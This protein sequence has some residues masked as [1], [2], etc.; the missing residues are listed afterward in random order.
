[1]SEWK[2]Y[3]IGDLCSTISNTYNGSDDK[4][5]LINT[6]DV[7]DGK[8]LNHNF[9]E[10]KNLKG[11][12]KK[13]FIKNDIL[14]SEIRPAN[15]RFAFIDF[16]KT[17]NY[18]VS[19]KLMVLRPDT[20]KVLPSFLFSILK[21]QTVIDELQHL[22]ETRSGTFPQITFSSELAPMKVLLPNL[23]IQAKIVSILYSIEEKISTN[24]A[25][26]NN[27]E[28]QAQAIFKSWFVDFE[29]FGGTMP[30][31]W[32]ISTLSIVADYLNGLAM[33]KF[34]PNKNEKGIPVLKIKELKQGFC[35]VQSDLCSI[36]IKPEYLIN[37]GD[38]IFSWSGTLLLDFWCSGLC[39]LNQHLFKVS[40][41]KYDKWFYYFWTKHHLDTFI[42][43]A[44]DKATTMGHIKREDLDKSE[45]LIPDNK[46][47]K[48]LNSILSPLINLIIKNRVE[49]RQL[50]QLR[51]T[52]LPKLMSG[53]IDVSKVDIS[54]DKLLFSILV[55]E[56]LYIKIVILIGVT[57]NTMT[58]FTSNIIK[59]KLKKSFT[60]DN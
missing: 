32:S 3:C 22:A 20:T 45:V 43:I 17:N 4:V 51:D 42:A 60:F 59:F 35:D 19:T 18:I 14:Y 12:F 56:H 21:S 48:Q 29:P 13:T 5:V 15:K 8:V 55:F 58:I 28:Q 2:N 31:D 50:T 23:D 1:M 9:V 46:T 25:I 10:N 40:S 53:E 47:Y 30:N 38:V 54:A 34:R 57:I 16:D 26:N 49:N 27:L 36:N 7:L 41:E 52:L 11:Q 6:S 37:D 44:A 39:G 33:Q 24:T